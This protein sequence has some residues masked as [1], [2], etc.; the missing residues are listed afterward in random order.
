MT[1]P[2]YTKRIALEASARK[3]ATGEQGPPGPMGPRGP[4]G[5]TGPAGPPG[6]PGTDGSGGGGATDHGALAGLADDDHP[7][8]LNN[9][10]GDARYDATGTASSAVAAHVAASDPHPQYLT[11]AEANAAY[12]PLSH[13]H[14]ASQISDST[15]AGRSMLTA[16]DAAAQRT[17]LNVANGA[18]ANATDAALRDRATH[19]GT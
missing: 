17:L 18:T 9:A 14:P 16:A 19:T 1:D 5:P 13:T 2:E 3:R 8:Y 4:V 11:P 7:Q 10:R 6:P 15:A 12:A